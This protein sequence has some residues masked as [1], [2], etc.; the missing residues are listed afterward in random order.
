MPFKQQALQ[1][2]VYVFGERSVNLVFV[3][4][5]L[6][7]GKR[8][9][10]KA[11]YGISDN[12]FSSSPFEDK[13]VL[14]DLQEIIKN[15]ADAETFFPALSKK[16]I[17]ICTDISCGIVPIDPAEREKREAVGRLCIR[18]AREATRVIKI[19]CGIARILKG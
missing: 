14:Y 16:Q 3:I 17:V 7:S 4:G 18:L 2:P 10:V 1:I 9:Y 6:A 12:G 19:E 13:P 8:D 11:E 15:D 5:G